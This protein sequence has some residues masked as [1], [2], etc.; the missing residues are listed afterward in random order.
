MFVHIPSEI[1][2]EEAE[3][4]G[5]EHLLRDIKDNAVGTLSSRITTQK[6]SLRG[7]VMR[8]QEIRECL[9]K[10]VNDKGSNHKTLPHALIYQLQDIFNCLPNLNQAD[11]VRAFSVKTNDQM[12]VL[13]LSSLIRAV[14][15]LHNLINNKLANRDAERQAEAAALPE[16]QVEKV[17]TKEVAAA[18]EKEQ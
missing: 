10:V 8:L 14:V 18:A 13:Y 5:V 1:E 17:E 4:I 11:I 12:L 7:L 9:E 6:N 2:A 3:E 16:E 15:A